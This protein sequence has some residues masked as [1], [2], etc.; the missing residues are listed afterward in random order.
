VLPPGTGKGRAL[1]RLARRLGIRRRETLAVGDW[2]NDTDM[3][4][5]A[6]IGVAMGNAPAEVQAAADWVTADCEQDGVALALE[7]FVLG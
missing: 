4:A 1:A 6:G 7:R 3:L 2:Y 5:W